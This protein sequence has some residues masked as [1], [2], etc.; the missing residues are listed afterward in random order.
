MD[1]YRDGSLGQS[2]FPVELSAVGITSLVLIF[3]PTI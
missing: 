2:G 1:E 3:H